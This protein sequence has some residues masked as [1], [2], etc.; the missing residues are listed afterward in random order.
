MFVDEVQMSQGCLLCTEHHCQDQNHS[1]WEIF[2]IYMVVW[3]KRREDTF[4]QKNWKWL[5]LWFLL[6]IKFFCLFV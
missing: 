6:N 3:K 2:F 4:F 5:K 1:V